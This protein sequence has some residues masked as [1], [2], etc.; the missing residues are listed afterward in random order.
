ML[1]RGR[2]RPI[3]PECLPSYPPHGPVGPASPCSSHG[4]SSERRNAPWLSCLLTRLPRT[5]PRVT[6]RRGPACGCRL[7]GSVP[8]DAALCGIPVKV[9]A[10]SPSPLFPVV[11][12]RGG[13]RWSSIAHQLPG[14]RLMPT[15]APFPTRSREVFPG[16]L[17]C[18]CLAGRNGCSRLSAQRSASPP[19]L[20]RRL[21]TGPPA[22][23]DPAR[24][25]VCSEVVVASPRGRSLG[26]TP[27]AQHE[28]PPLGGAFVPG[29]AV[30]HCRVYRP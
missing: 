25:G 20:S 14:G 27:T 13:Y 5:P 17:P 11:H 6:F 28:S 18:L 24:V 29:L 21:R 23:S 19:A 12:C 30:I 9:P 4:S 22:F 26:F 16:F 15:L 10:S 3:A 8:Q 7:R 2:W 1:P